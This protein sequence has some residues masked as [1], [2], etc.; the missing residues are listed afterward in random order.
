MVLT[1]LLT[2]DFSFDFKDSESVEF[3]F[4]SNDRP[5]RDFNVPSDLLELFSESAD[6]VDVLVSARGGISS[7][8]NFVYVNHKY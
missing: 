2:F 5:C 4:S 7:D 1:L 8:T 6:F 3:S